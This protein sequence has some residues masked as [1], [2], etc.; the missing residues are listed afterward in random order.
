MTRIAVVVQARMASTRLPGKVLLPVSGVPLLWRMLERVR[1]ATTPFELVLA[2]TRESS[3]DT[4]ADLGAAAGVHVVRGHSTDLI[5]RHVQAARAVRADVVVKIPS[6]CPLIDPDAIDLVVGAFLRSQGQVD[7]ASNLHPATW[8]DGHDVE[9]MTLE[10]LEHAW[11]EAREPHEREHT[12]PFLWDQPQRFRCLNI[13]DPA[14][15]D[16]SMSHRMTLDYPEDYA[17]VRATYDAL[18]SVRRPIFGLAE[19]LRLL[20][21]QPEI[22]ALNAKYAGVNW[23]RNHLADLRTVRAEETRCPPT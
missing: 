8:P 17:F 20:E 19:I 22:H 6:D 7:Y 15:R 18:W 5:H 11:R 12:T 2:T 9:V 10:A 3:D 14:G 21:E 13:V 4:I 1:A 23:Y 16:L